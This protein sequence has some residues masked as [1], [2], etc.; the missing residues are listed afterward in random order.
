MDVERERYKRQ[1][2]GRGRFRQ[3]QPEL[4]NIIAHTKWVNLAAVWTV[5]L[6]YNT[7]LPV[8]ARQRAGGAWVF[9]PLR[10]PAIEAGSNPDAIAKFS[11]SAAVCADPAHRARCCSGAW[12]LTASAGLRHPGA[13]EHASPMI[14]VLYLGWRE[15]PD[16]ASEETA[17]SVAGDAAERMVMR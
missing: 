12:R 10:L 11:C 1:T 4:D 16:A 3:K 2:E 8:N 6:P 5:D 13:A 15:R 17:L 9:T 14:G 7:A